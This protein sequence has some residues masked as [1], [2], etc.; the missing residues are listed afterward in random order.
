M[1]CLTLMDNAKQGNRPR[2]AAAKKPMDNLVPPPVA[3]GTTAQR[4]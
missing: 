4:P 1:I 2:D 3:V